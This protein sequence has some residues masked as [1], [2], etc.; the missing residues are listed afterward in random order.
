[1]SSSGRR[2]GLVAAGVLALTACSGE[3]EP[4]PDPTA[5]TP[6]G[7]ELPD[8][9]E[10]TAPGTT[11]E[12]GEAAT[13]VLELGDGAQSAT[14][15][16]VV[17]VREGSIKDFRY[18]SLDEQ[19]RTATPFYVDVAVTNEGPAGL[20]GISVPLLAHSDA[21]TVYPASELV[22]TFDP[23]ESGPL[24]KTF[25]AGE[26]ASQCFIFLLPE[27]EDLQTIDLQPGAAADAVHWERP[28]PDPEPTD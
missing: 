25:L 7:L 26:S 19:S 20:G 22:G 16:E 14:T 4:A 18:F 9:V 2:L 12:V 17:R 5:T 21:N 13:V 6:A 15:V 27:G 28:E 24:P 8:G 10:L 23:C 3:P 1:M 11:L